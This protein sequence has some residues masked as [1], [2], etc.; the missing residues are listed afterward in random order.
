MNISIQTQD[1]KAQKKLIN[2]V[3]SHVMKLS[4]FGDLILEAHVVLKLDPSDS[5]DNKVCEV[6]LVVPGND[7]FAEKQSSTFEDAAVKCVEAVRHQI[8]RWKDS[9]NHG[10]LRGS[11]TPAAEEA[12]M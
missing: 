3:K 11:A 4:V 7:L 8:G 6:K 12:S 10:K 2:Y 5:G 9:V 1:F